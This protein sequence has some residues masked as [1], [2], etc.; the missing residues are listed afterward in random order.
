MPI[1]PKMMKRIKLHRI[2]KLLGTA[3]NLADELDLHLENGAEV[4]GLVGGI[5]QELI[6]MRDKEA[7]TNEV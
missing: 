1:S 6:L 3:A 7:K 4:G 5:E 2:I